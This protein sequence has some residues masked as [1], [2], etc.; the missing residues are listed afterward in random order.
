VEQQSLENM[1]P[2]STRQ[3]RAI[4][5]IRNE[6]D[7]SRDVV[8]SFDFEIPLGGVSNPQ[9]P[10]Q[11]DSKIKGS[12]KRFRYLFSSIPRSKI[13]CAILSG[14]CFLLLLLFYVSYKHL[15]Y[16]S[17][18]TDSQ[19]PNT[20]LNFYNTVQSDDNWKKKVPKRNGHYTY[21]DPKSHEI[22]LGEL[23]KTS[24]LIQT[25][26]KKPNLVFYASPTWDRLRYPQNDS[27]STRPQSAPTIPMY[28]NQVLD[29]ML[30]VSPGE[31]SPPQTQLRKP[32]T[33]GNCVPMQEWQTDSKPSCNRLHEIDMTWERR[34]RNEKKGEQTLQFG[35][36][37]WFR[38]AWVVEETN[39]MNGKTR[40]EKY[41]LKTLR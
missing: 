9:S 11:D 3:R 15:L 8:E 39:A 23:I 18:S 32:Y 33:D 37:G 20:S 41:I 12:K 10:Q 4:A 24:P 27:S 35:G 22:V 38:I 14:V 2:P 5:S 29:P 17:K 13:K 7:G 21:T 26:D 30:Q 25:N 28:T 6:Y 40:T 16:P 31:E 36:K 19:F 1:I 34:F